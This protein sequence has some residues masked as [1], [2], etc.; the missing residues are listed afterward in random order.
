MYDFHLGSPEEIA[1]DE[2]RY[3]IAV[4]RMMP[5]W[6]NS[7]ADSEFLALAQLADE[8]GRRAKE[9]GRRFVAVETGVGASTLALIFYAL[10]YDGVAYTWDF[11]TAKTSAVRQVATETM[12]IHL[13][14]HVDSAWHPV[15]YL[16]TSEHLGLPILKELVDG[17]DL[18]FHDSEHTWDVLGAEL[19]AVI[20]ILRDGAVVALDDANLDYAHTNVGYINTFRRK[21]GL[22][23]I[24]PIEGNTTEPFYVQAERLLNERFDSVEYLPDLYKERYRSD[25]YFS[26]YK[27]EFEVK[28]DL[29]TERNEA[30]EHRFDSWRV[31]CRRA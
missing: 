22:G 11:N 4:K 19:D 5:R 30:L 12:G 20:P 16:S 15:G 10:K 13:G 8:Q 7:V 31:S 9:A 29:G 25:P 18:T 6:I 28:S 27:A 1:A 2:S 3:L 23:D 24:A 21:M 26:Y 14:K 17:V